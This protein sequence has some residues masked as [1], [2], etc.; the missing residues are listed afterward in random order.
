ML[1]RYHK[2]YYF[3]ELDF[4]TDVREGSSKGHVKAIINCEKQK[5]G[6]QSYSI[7]IHLTNNLTFQCILA[8]F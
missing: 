2:Y 4:P 6:S 1:I 7:S 8:T 5:Q 3:N